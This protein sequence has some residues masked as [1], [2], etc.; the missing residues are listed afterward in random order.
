MVNTLFD[1][2]AGVDDLAWLSATWN[3]PL[4]VK[5]VQTAADARRVVDAGSDAVVLSNHGGRQ[6][7]RAV[8]PLEELPA[9]LDQVGGRAEIYLDGGI[10]R[11]ADTIAAV[12]FGA[13]A[14]LV[15]H[16]Y[17]YGLMAGGQAGV[18]RA[19]DILGADRRRI[20]ALFGTPTLARLRRGA[21]DDVTAS[22]LD[23][24]RSHLERRGAG[25][26][27]ERVGVGMAMHSRSHARP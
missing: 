4:V 22:N 5:G 12:A 11:G 15:G 9:A 27:D 19:L 8:T 23:L 3:G 24:L 17:L 7:D 13:R 25:L 2:A 21:D 18:T 14:C 16:A 26:D 6:L 10:R 1:A 20:L